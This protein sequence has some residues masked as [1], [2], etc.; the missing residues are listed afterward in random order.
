VI[1]LPLKEQ[2]GFIGEQSANGDEV[3]VE[4]EKAFV[5]GSERFDKR[6]FGSLRRVPALK[7]KIEEAVA[8]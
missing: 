8:D 4:E 6:A 7:G 2:R 3:A 5:E 1:R